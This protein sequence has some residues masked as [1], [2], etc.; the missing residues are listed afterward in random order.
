M[1]HGLILWGAVMAAM[2]W[3]TASGVGSGFSGMMRVSSGAGENSASEPVWVEAA[4]RANLSQD[5]IDK[6]KAGLEDP[7][8]AQKNA[9]LVSWGT[10]LGVLLSMGAAIAGA[11]TG[12]GPHRY[13]LWG[14]RT[15]QRTSTTNTT[16][17]PVASHI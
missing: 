12:G 7:E 9:R 4:R 1:I 10:L 8:T 16:D 5:Q 14:G 11:Y 15:L 3:M 17:K 2:L 13:S 6:I